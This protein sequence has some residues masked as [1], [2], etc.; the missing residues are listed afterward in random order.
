MGIQYESQT[1]DKVWTYALLKAGGVWYVTGN[2]KAPVAAGWGAINRWLERDGRIV[3]WVK[4]GTGWT[5]LYP[6]RIEGQRADQVIVDD[7][8]PVDTS[9]ATE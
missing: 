5:D 6:A 7:P 2:G 8:S 9:Q 3:L 1:S 4:V